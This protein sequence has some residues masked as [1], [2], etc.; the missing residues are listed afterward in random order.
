MNNNQVKLKIA[1]TYHFYDHQTSRSFDIPCIYDY[2]E[3]QVWAIMRKVKTFLATFVYVPCIVSDCM[4]LKLQQVLQRKK[5]YRFKLKKDFV[6][7]QSLVRRTIKNFEDDFK[8]PEFFDEF[9]MTYYD[10]A[11]PKIEKFAKMMEVK[12]ANLGYKDVSVMSL[13]FLAFQMACFGVVNYQS[14]MRG[15][16]TDYGFDLTGLYAHLCPTQPSE[17][18]KRF[19]MDVGF[20]EELV[21]KLNARDDISE[22]FSRI[23]KTF[24]S[25][26][27]QRKASDAAFNELPEE[28]KER[29]SSGG[30]NLERELEAIEKNNLKKKPK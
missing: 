30:K 4:M 12:L 8:N 5:M 16:E 24:I 19:M 27:T 25:Q 17:A 9:S 6:N 10:E 14:L 3:D 15:A 18:A 29:M 23:E 11:K 28:T 26:A 1:R 13:S 21:K 2:T 22:L 20:T 7:M